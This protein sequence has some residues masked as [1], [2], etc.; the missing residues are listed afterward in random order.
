MV[1]TKGHLRKGLIIL[2]VGLTITM[3]RYIRYSSIQ[4][5]LRLLDS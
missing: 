3:R 1:R 5:E 2:L 4:F